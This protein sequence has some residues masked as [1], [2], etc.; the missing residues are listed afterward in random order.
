MWI[1]QEIYQLQHI[2]MNG[3]LTVLLPKSSQEV[4]GQQDHIQRIQWIFNISRANGAVT[5]SSYK[6]AIWLKFVDN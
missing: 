5:E 2:A 3:A 6:F 1:F 4:T